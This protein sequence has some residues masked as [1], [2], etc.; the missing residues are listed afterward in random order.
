MW[1]GILVLALQLGAA[2]MSVAD[3]LQL[4]PIGDGP[5]A[6]PG[7]G[8]AELSGIVWLGGSRFLAVDDGDGHLVDLDL[9]LDEE[10]G[11]VRSFVASVRATLADA[12][13]PEGIALRPGHESVLV[14]DEGHRDLREYDASSGE[15]LRQIAPPPRYEGRLKKNTGFESITSVPDGDTIWIA[16]EGPLRLDGSGPTMSK[17]GW[18][19]LQ[20][21][22]ASLTPTAQYAYQTEAGLG[23]VGVVDL[24]ATPE[25]ELLVLERALVGTGFAAR[26]FQVDV[27]PATDVTSFEKLRNRDD[28]QPVWKRPV[29]ERRHGFQNFEGMALGPPLGGGGRLV[30]LVSDGG[31]HRAPQLLP[32]RMTRPPPANPAPTPGVPAP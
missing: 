23:Y 12:Q 30:L 6:I 19:R 28:F 14:V 13:D 2:G 3:E 26:I 16:T 8:N 4:T 32:L 27:S 15:L 1:P 9:T 29:W 22:D 24:L 18:I 10:T 31:G 7:I 25:G 20:R 5:I 21:F 11:A 17:G